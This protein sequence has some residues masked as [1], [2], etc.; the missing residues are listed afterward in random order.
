MERELEKKR[1]AQP[2]EETT[3]ISMEVDTKPD[4]EVLAKITAKKPQQNN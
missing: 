2:G 4:L 3:Q 1:Q